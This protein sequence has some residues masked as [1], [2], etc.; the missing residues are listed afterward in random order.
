MSRNVSVETKDSPENERRSTE[1]TP[2]DETKAEQA[3]RSLVRQMA[4]R[5]LPGEREMAAHLAISRPRLRAL[6][7]SLQAEGLVQ[8]RQGSGT[9]AL[10]PEREGSLRRIV[11]LID[12][13]LKLGDDPFFSLLVERLQSALQSAG[14][15]CIIER[16]SAEGRLP[17]VEDGAI[18]MG[19]AGSA[20]IERQRPNAPPVVGLL[21]GPEVRP[22]RR[23]SVFQLEDQQAGEEAVRHLL[24]KGCRNILFVGRHDIAAS[25]ERLS[26]AQLAVAAAGQEASLRVIDCPLNYGGGLALGREIEMPVNDGLVGIIAANDWLA[27]GLRTGL[28]QR[29]REQADSSN[30]PIVSF[31]GLPLASDPALQIASL[32]VPIESIASDAVAELRRLHR[33]GG[34]AGRIV[35]YPL[36]WADYGNPG[37]FKWDPQ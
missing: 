28:Q 9:Y 1:A 21:L 24:R 5:R 36:C 27:V 6:L 8:S 32:A 33:A 31:D 20:L 18:T 29:R 19:L 4:G 10:D 22:N 26:G 16:A 3:L 30:M 23:A 14:M 37:T 25:R 34:P 2:N 12:N 17:S 11:L 35:R 15:R 13:S 7:S